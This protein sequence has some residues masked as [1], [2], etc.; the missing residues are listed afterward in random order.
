MPELKP[1]PFG[2]HRSPTARPLLPRS[3][4]RRAEGSAAWQHLAS[5]QGREEARC[6]MTKAVGSPTWNP[7]PHPKRGTTGLPF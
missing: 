2:Q 7:K 4:G 6:D 1:V 3:G 5:L